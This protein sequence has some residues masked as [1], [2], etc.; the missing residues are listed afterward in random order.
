MKP[1]LSSSDM[2]IESMVIELL[3]HEFKWKKQQ[4]QKKVIAILYHTVL[5]SMCVD[6]AVAGTYL[7][8][9]LYAAANR[10]E[11]RFTIY[12]YVKRNG[13]MNTRIP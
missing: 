5:Y 10:A 3:V 2:S 4:K 7:C 9:L 12:I 1:E 8:A 13:G 6:D 11:I